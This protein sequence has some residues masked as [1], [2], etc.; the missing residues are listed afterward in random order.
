[1]NLLEQIQSEFNIFCKW[2]EDAD[3][4]YHTQCGEVWFFDTGTIKENKA[5]YCTYCG[6]LIKEEEYKEESEKEE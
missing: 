5:K 2:Q 6:R 4:I 1:M 3:G